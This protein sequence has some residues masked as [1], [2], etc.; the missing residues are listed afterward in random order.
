MA[1]KVQG[2]KELDKALQ[3]LAT[4]TSVRV[5]R[6]GLTAAL[7]PVA[8]QARGSAPRSKTGKKHMADTIGVS[9]KL[10][11]AQAKEA[12]GKDGRDVVTMFVGARDPKAHLVEFG[13]T[14]RHHASGKFVGA[15]PPQPFMRPAWD[16]NRDQVLAS[17]GAFIWAE[18]EKTAARAAKRSAKLAAKGG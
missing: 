17:L 11:P 18:I 15:M 1:I 16:A 13:T 5:A 8:A 7:E 12:R 14:P 6:R 9:H 4:S 10:T 2:L 3:A